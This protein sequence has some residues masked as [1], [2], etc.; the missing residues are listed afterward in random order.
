MNTYMNSFI[1]SPITRSNDLSHINEVKNME[2]LGKFKGVNI[3]LKIIF[4]EGQIKRI[5]SIV[6]YGLKLPRMVI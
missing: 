4:E 5:N 1:V 6:E 3:L 2:L